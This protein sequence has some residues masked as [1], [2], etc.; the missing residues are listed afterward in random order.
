MDNAIE[1]MLSNYKPINITERENALK[2]IIQEIALAGLYKN[3]LFTCDSFNH[4]NGTLIS[5]IR[6]HFFVVMLFSSFVAG[7]FL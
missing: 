5:I 7:G 4:V 2:E 1:M 3:S 6:V